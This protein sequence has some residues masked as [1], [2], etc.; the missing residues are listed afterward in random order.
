VLFVS[1]PRLDTLPAHGDL[2]YCI[3][4]RRHVMCFSETCLRGLLGRAG[5]TTAGRLDT[6][7]LDAVFTEGKPLRLRLVA[8]RTRHQDPLPDAPLV[9]AVEALDRYARGKESAADRIRR[10]LPVRIRGGILNRA[11]AR[12]V[13]ERRQGLVGSPGRQGAGGE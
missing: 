6:H 7:E 5:F 1:V 8:V 10:L 3:S 12:R 2:D 4:G 11:A 9:P 13:S